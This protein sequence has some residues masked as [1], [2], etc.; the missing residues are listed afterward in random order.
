MTGLGYDENLVNEEFGELSSKKLIRRRSNRD[1]DEN[2]QSYYRVSPTGTQVLAA[3]KSL[4]T[5]KENMSLID[6]EIDTIESLKKFQQKSSSVETI[7]AIVILTSSGVQITNILLN[8]LEGFWLRFFFVV[9]WQIILYTSLFAALAGR[10]SIS[11]TLESEFI[12]P[13]RQK[14][15]DFSLSS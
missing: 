9:N 11:G 15:R 14:R 5:S 10:E 2:R 8:Q 6:T 4:D 1:E 7:F 12:Q 13:I 3:K